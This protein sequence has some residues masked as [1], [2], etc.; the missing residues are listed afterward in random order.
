[1]PRRSFAGVLLPTTC[2]C[3]GARGAAPCAA[4]RSEL[5]PPPP[6]DPPLGVDGWVAL[7]AY[8]GVGRELVARLKYR[9]ARSALRWLAAGLAELVDPAGLDV[10][11][12]APTTPARRRARGF[13]QAELLAR[14]LARD[15]GRPCRGLLRRGPGPAQTGRPAPE[16]RNGLDLRS[17]ANPPRRVLVVDDVATTGTTL[18]SVATALRASGTVEVWAATAARTPA[19]AGRLPSAAPVVDPGGSGGHQGQWPSHGGL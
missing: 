5:R 12:W 15:L 2:P 3:C 19:R 6:A 8:E 1:M 14:R 18:A 17:V 13:D 11:T 4:C 7:L 9:N 10:V 16:R